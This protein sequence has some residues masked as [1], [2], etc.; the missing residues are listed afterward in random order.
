MIGQI[1][2]RLQLPS[3]LG[4]MHN[5]FHVPRIKMY[6]PDPQYVLATEEIELQEDLSF[7]EEHVEILDRKVKVLRT[8]TIP[9]VKVLWQYHDVREATCE[10]QERMRELYP[11]LFANPSINF[12]DKILLRREECETPH[13]YRIVNNNIMI[14]MND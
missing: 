3:N 13:I 8:K 1:A 4:E 7:K 6:C 10:M 12:E 5:V 2:Y 9:L 14:K 11:Q